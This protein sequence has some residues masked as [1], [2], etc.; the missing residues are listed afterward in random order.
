MKILKINFKTQRVYE[1]PIL[2]NHF[3]SSIINGIFNYLSLC[4]RQLFFSSFALVNSLFRFLF[5]LVIADSDSTNCNTTNGYHYL[6][7][8]R[9]GVNHSL[10]KV[11][12]K[13]YLFSVRVGIFTT[14]YFSR[15]IV[16]IGYDVESPRNRRQ[17]VSMLM[18]VETWDFTFLFLLVYSAIG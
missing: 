16:R 1:L 13:I 18:L 4:F 6:A 17:S 8:W 7:S 3:E 12:G 5:C 2:Y 11:Y 10:I 14:L 15:L 9:F